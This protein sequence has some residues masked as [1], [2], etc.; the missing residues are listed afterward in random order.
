VKNKM[1]IYDIDNLVKNVVKGPQ[2]PPVMGVKP[3]PGMQV[4]AIR[5]AEDVVRIIQKILREAPAVQQAS[6][7]IT[8]KLTT[9]NAPKTL[10]FQYR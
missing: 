7:Q 6:G 5:T 3:T 2:A 4:S 8:V 9:S 1:G 10:S